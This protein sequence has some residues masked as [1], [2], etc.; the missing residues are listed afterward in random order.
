MEAFPVTQGENILFWKQIA[1]RVRLGV[2]GPK[3]LP[4]NT[5]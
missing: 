3:L 4:N 2:G 5:R 1:R